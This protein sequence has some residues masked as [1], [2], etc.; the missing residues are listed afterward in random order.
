ML[1]SVGPTQ[2]SEDETELITTKLYNISLSSS[3]VSSD[4][5][6]L[7]SFIECHRKERRQ[8]SQDPLH[9]SLLDTTLRR[10][11]T[12]LS[13]LDYITPSFDDIEDAVGLMTVANSPPK[14]ETE[15]SSNLNT[16]FANSKLQWGMSKWNLEGSKRG[17][18]LICF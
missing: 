17:V 10:L 9:S 18:S 15:W 4:P 7:P 3:S 13:N 8:N 5:T 11:Y 6:T 2:L 14:K 12:N 1:K 16:W